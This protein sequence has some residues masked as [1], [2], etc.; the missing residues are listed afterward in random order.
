[1]LLA[2]VL[3]EFDLSFLRDAAALVDSK[4]RALNSKRS[5]ATDLIIGKRVLSDNECA[6]RPN[7]ALELPF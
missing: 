1:M 5:A 2:D 6:L 3:H 4:L 7:T